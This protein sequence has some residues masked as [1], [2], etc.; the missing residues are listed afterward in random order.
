MKRE[1]RKKLE[2]VLNTPILPKAAS[3]IDPLVTL[4]VIDEAER[5]FRYIHKKGYLVGRDGYQV[6]LACLYHSCLVYGVP[7]SC[8]ELCEGHELKYHKVLGERKKIER[9][10]NL[11]RVGGLDRVI[12]F[13]QRFLVSL[14]FSPDDEIWRKCLDVA[15]SVDE[16]PGSS[17]IG[18]VALIYAVSRVLGVYGVTQ[19][20]LCRVSGVTEITLRKRYR[21]LMKKNKE[22]FM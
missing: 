16:V 5:L 22:V 8:Q 11:D 20:R 15:C 7:I 18:A 3:S 4:E 12:P 9:A 6:A 21:E 1:M 10:F 2:E 17:R 13:V 14:G 19:K